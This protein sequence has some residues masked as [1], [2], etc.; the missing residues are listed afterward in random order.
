[1]HAYYNDMYACVYKIIFLP[2]ARQTIYYYYYYYYNNG[3]GGTV[4]RTKAIVHTL[5]TR[6][7]RVCVFPSLRTS[8]RDVALH[9]MLFIHARARPERRFSVR[10]EDGTRV[11]LWRRPRGVRGLREVDGQASPVRTSRGTRRLRKPRFV[12]WLLDRVRQIFFGRSSPR[13]VPSAC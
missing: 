4:R 2:R 9:V 11:V 6:R 3:E 7:A 1:M 8:S 12:R 5:H 13:G 10:D